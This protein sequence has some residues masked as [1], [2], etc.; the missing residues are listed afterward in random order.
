MSTPPLV[1]LVDQTEEAGGE[2][3]T[4]YGKGEYRWGSFPGA[5]RP[6]QGVTIHYTAGFTLE[7]A[8]AALLRKGLSYHYIVDKDGT[9]YMMV[10]PFKYGAAHAGGPNQRRVPGATENTSPNMGTVG[11]SFINVGYAR[12]NPDG[13]KILPKADWIESGGKWW[14]PYTQAQVEA[15]ARVT[16]HFLAENDLDASKMWSHK[17]LNKGGKSDPGPAFP[18]ET[19][20]NRV[21]FWISP[22]VAVTAP[23][24]VQVVTYGVRENWEMLALL[25][26]SGAVVYTGYRVYEEGLEMGLPFGVAWR[27]V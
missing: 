26:L 13:S 1:K 3:W 27:T 15:A 18:M 25:A 6:P 21:A 9:V 2:R 4:R 22:P 5:M 14:E 10:D 8:K 17:E 7:G 24:P 12:T 19:F 23:G 20:R 11:L 16:G